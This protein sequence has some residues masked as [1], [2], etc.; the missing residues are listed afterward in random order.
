MKW[1]EGAL[2]IGGLSF[3][4]LIISLSLLLADRFQVRG[5]GCPKV[6][7]HNFIWL[8]IGLATIFV[9]SLF[10]FLFSLKI[11]QKEKVISKNMEVLN[12]ILDDDEN[13]A[14]DMLVKNRGEMPQATLSKTHGKIK[15]H[16]LLKKLEEKNIIDIKKKGKT[17]KVILKKELR[18][19]LVK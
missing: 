10:Y 15:A 5:C 6:V 8:F 3:L 16:R 13:K 14:L 17:N 7:S 1:R 18:E 19:E 4:T 9:A 11:E 2:I 12:S